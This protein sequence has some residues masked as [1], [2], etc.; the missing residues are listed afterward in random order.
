MKTRLYD[1]SYREKTSECLKLCY[2]FPEFS[3]GFN[4]LLKAR[5][6]Y[7]LDVCVVKAAKIVDR[8]SP[9]YYPIKNKK[10]MVLINF[11]KKLCK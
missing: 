3:Y 11:N 10:C 1:D 8:L 5:S 7:K 9:N 4:W 2:E 6:R